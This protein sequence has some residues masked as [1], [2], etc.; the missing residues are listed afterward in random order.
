MRHYRI[1]PPSENSRNK[2]L[3]FVGIGVAVVVI[4]AFVLL[5]PFL[6]ESE[7]TK[8]IAA[9]V[10]DMNN[11]KQL[12]G[13]MRAERSGAAPDGRLDVYGPL[14]KST[15]DK[16]L[17]VDV[18]RSSR[19]GKG[20]TLAQIEANDYSNF[21]WKRAKAPFNWETTRVR[22]LLWDGSPQ[23]RGRRVVALNSGAVKAVPEDEFAAYLAE[24]NR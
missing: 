11:L 20:P 10:E 16:K 19:S 12:V 8:Q 5:G 13:S 22:V 1:P 23:P 15:R 17:W 14:K 4:L 3:L 24:R 9:Q 21:P 2:V 18:C 6:S 7:E